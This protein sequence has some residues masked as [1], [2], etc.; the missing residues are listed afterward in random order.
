MS[1]LILALA[2]L[3]YQDSNMFSLLAIDGGKVRVGNTD[4]TDDLSSINCERIATAIKRG[5]RFLRAKGVAEISMNTEGSNANLTKYRYT[6]AY[7]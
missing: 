2:T 7:I 5:G 3:C 4:P 1:V 6:H